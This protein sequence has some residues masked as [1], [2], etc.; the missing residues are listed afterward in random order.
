MKNKK[1]IAAILVVV[2]CALFGWVQTKILDEREDYR[3]EEKILMLS[4]RPKVTR[5]LSL[6]FEGALSDLL[7]VRA[8]QYFGGNFSTLNKPEKKEG[9][10]NLFKNIVGLDPHFIE[11]Y[12]FGGFVFNESINDTNLA[13]DFLLQGAENNENIKTNESWRLRFD[14]GFIAFYQLEDYDF[15]KSQ[16]IQTVFGENVAQQV[17]VEA[18]GLQEGSYPDSVIDGDPY[19][20]SIFN[21][22]NGSITLTF[23][24]PQQIGRINIQSRSFS[25]QSFRLRYR[26]SEGA[27]PQLLPDVNQTTFF[28]MDPVITAQRLILDQFQSDSEEG[29]FSLSEILIYGPRNEDVP[30]YVERMIYEMDRSAGRFRAAFQ[31]QLRYYQ[32]AKKKGDDVGATIAWDKLN[33]IYSSKCIEILEQAVTLYKENEGELPSPSMVEVLERGYLSQ[34]IQQKIQEDPQFEEDVLSVLLYRSKNNL[35]EILTTF[36]PENPQPHLLITETDAEGNLDWY[37]TS[38]RVLKESQTAKLETLQTAVAKYKEE[39]GKL[40][41]QLTDLTKESWFSSSETI[42]EDPLGGEFVLNQET[43]KVSSINPK[44]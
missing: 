7:W 36:D 26:E 22:A 37:I 3:V 2:L 25:N 32:E 14:A 21:P 43:G 24:S 9:M 39:Y 30:P 29:T 17:N 20:E 19:S 38:R 33:S 15:A 1:T 28:D 44:Y 10:I 16:F 6:G 34:V 35:A 13:I 11:A 12:K 4:N 23:D 5:I 41:D 31:Q 8:I 18:Q 40:P 27:A 42:F